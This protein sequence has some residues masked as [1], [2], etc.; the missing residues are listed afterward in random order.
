MTDPSREGPHPERVLESRRLYD[1]R[2]MVLRVDT[3]LMPNGREATRE[4]VE[5]AP[6]VAVVPV[7]E[8]GDVVLVRQYHLATGDVMLEVPAGLVDEGEEIEAAAQR[9]LQEEIGYR[10]GH[11]ERLAGFFVSPGFCTE[12]IHVFLALGLEQ[13]DLAADED[14]DITVER[15]PLAEAARLVETGE[16]R[17]AKS[18]VGIL[19]ARER[20]AG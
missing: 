3:V 15:V 5:H 2:I 11:L 19:M 9:E 12:F 1:G 17:D 16:I 7:D 14:E 18:I 13:S 10:A 6:V 4:I 20:M 8:N